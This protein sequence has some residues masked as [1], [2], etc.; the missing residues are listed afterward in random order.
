MQRC[1]CVS[2]RMFWY[3][4]LVL[5]GPFALRQS[6]L[7]LQSVTLCK[8]RRS[9]GVQLFLQ[10]VTR[11]NSVNSDMW[12]VF[13]ACFCICVCVV[14]L[15]TFADTHENR[16]C[17]TH[18]NIFMLHTSTPHTHNIDTHMNIFMLHT[19]TPH[20][21]KYFYTHE[22]IYFSYSY[23]THTRTH[24]HTLPQICTHTHTQ[25]DIHIQTL[26]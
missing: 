2:T 11:L 25:S 20:T 4:S 1:P 8:R 10:S 13:R 7:F 3:K 5:V 15:C 18:M 9:C 14:C 21:H 22:Y 23:T 26:T 19:A 17:Y 16:Y 24:Q 6:L 12:P